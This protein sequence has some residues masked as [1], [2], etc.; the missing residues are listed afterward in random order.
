[1]QLKSDDVPGGYVRAKK[2]ILVE[3]YGMVGF[4]DFQYLINKFKEPGKNNL[5]GQFVLTVAPAHPGGAATFS[6]YSNRN[7]HQLQG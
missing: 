5:L 1:L 2:P 6:A 3:S 4:F 7:F